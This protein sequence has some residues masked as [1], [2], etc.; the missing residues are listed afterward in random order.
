MKTIFE[1]MTIQRIFNC[2][3]MLHVDSLE[4]LFSYFNNKPFS[5]LSEYID[6][7]PAFFN[8]IMAPTLIKIL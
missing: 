4:N 1:K 5:L 7:Y 6:R 3:Y 8:P 2:I